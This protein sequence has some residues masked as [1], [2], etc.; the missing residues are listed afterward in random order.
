MRRRIVLALDFIAL[1]AK[2]RICAIS[3]GCLLCLLFVSPSL[4]VFEQYGLEWVDSFDDWTID[5]SHIF[6]CCCWAWLLN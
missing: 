5:G 6:V 3:G 4:Q 1:V 2:C